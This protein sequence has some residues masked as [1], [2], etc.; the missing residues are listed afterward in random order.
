MENE[1]EDLLFQDFQNLLCDAMRGNI[2]YSS[3][4][5]VFKTLVQEATFKGSAKSYQALGEYLFLIA[6]EQAIEEI[7]REVR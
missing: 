5:E 6:Y 7:K 2:G 1:V 4:D 3:R